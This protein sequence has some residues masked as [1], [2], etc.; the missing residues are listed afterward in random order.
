[1]VVPSSDQFSDG[2]DTVVENFFR[3][4]FGD[5]NA[6]KIQYS[7]MAFSCLGNILVQT[8]TAARV[9]QEIAKEGIL[10][11]SKFFADNKTLTPAFL[12]GGTSST[13]DATPIGAFCLHWVW[14]VILILCSIGK[15]S[16]ESY[17]IFVS[18]YAFVVEAIMGFAIGLG[19]LVLRFRPSVHWADK[20]NSNKYI[21]IGTALVFTIANCFPLIA[22]WFQP[23]GDSGLKL[24]FTWYATGTIGIGLM[25]FACLWWVGLRYVVPSLIGRELVVER[26]ATFTSPWGYKVLFHEIT[27]INWRTRSPSC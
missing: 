11:F 21:S 5:P 20:S 18:L 27:S 6:S 1:M 8:F 19:I 24:P 2:S 7:L 15:D 25:G 23:S 22:V 13:S 9:K 12:R 16:T 4:A 3:K 17:R 26:E 14:S 10:P